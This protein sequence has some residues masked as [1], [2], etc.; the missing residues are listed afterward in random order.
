MPSPLSGVR[1][2]FRNFSNNKREKENRQLDDLVKY[3]QLAES[4]YTVRQEPKRGMFG[5]SQMVLERDPS[6]GAIV[7]EGFTRVSGKIVRDPS[8]LNPLQKRRMEMTG[9]DSGL[10]A[11]QRLAKDKATQDLFATAEINDVKRSVYDKALQGSE[12]IPQGFFGK[13]RINTAKSFP[14][15]KG[16]LRVNDKMIQDA[17]E[18]KM[19]LTDATLANAAYTKGAISDKEMSEFSK[20]SANDDFNS[21]AIFPV[22]AKLKAFL[23]AEEAGKFGAYQ[24]N[25]GEDPRTFLP[26]FGQGASQQPEQGGDP[27]EAEAQQAIANGADPNAVMQRLQQMRASRG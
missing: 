7:P 19:A 15:F 20:A 6:F 23:D 2:S 8:Y 12:T 4:G 13:A 5:R 25:Y 16:V 22:L 11:G 27:L 9:G 14:S 17:Q 18:L 26:K 24:K 21:P 10:T 1:E 3:A